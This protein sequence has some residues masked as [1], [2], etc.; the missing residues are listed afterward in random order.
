MSITIP[1][2][3]ITDAQTLSPIRGARK[4][5]IINEYIAAHLPGGERVVDLQRDGSGVLIALTETI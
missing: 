3:I 1:E 2:D 4:M 5:E